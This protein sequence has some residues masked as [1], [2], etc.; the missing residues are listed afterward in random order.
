MNENLIKK[1]TD[2]SKVVDANGKPIKPIVQATYN[3]YVEC[4]EKSLGWKNGFERFLKSKSGDHDRVIVHMYH[5]GFG[6]N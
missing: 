4:I 1:T 3:E 5:N 2:H 6:V